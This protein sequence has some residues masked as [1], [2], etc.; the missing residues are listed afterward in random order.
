MYLGDIFILVS[1]VD[2]AESV[3]QMIEIYSQIIECKTGRST[4]VNNGAINGIR[5]GLSNGSCV[6]SVTIFICFIKLFIINYIIA[7][8]L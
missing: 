6:A 4:F 5:N 3:E 2:H 8:Y 1:A 7:L